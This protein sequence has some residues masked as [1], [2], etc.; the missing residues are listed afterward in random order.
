[1][2]NRTMTVIRNQLGFDFGPGQGHKA[3][4]SQALPGS[5][6]TGLRPSERSWVAW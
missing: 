3:P 2:E 6:G 4:E 5:R 1:M